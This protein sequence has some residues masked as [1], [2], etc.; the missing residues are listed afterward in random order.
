PTRTGYTFTGWDIA[1]NNITADLTV[2]AQYS[3]NQYTVTFVD[4]NGSVLKTEQ[5]DHGASATTPA[6][7]T[8][9]G[10]TLTGWDVAFNNIPADLTVTAQY[11]I[12]QYTLSFHSQGGSPVASIS[13]DF[14]DNVVLPAAP[15]RTGYTFGN[16]NT[17][18]NGSGTAYM[19]R[20]SLTVPATNTTL[21]A[22]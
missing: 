21:Y 13:A 14:G 10:Y 2:T 16:W 12:N 18:A 4:W 17:A 3:I 9:E 5:V 20:A 7:P 8:R 1:F 22:I 6:D 11:S 19:P 15:V